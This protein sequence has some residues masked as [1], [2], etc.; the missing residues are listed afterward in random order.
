MSTCTDNNDISL[1][2]NRGTKL[3]ESVSFTGCGS[4]FVGLTLIPE[5]RKRV[6]GG[7][8]DYNILRNP[9]VVRSGE[10]PDQGECDPSCPYRGNNQRQNNYQQAP[11]P[12]YNQNYDR[13]APAQNQTGYYDNSQPQQNFG[14][15]GNNC[16]VP[17]GRTQP[18]TKDRGG[19]DCGCDPPSG[20]RAYRTPSSHYMEYREFQQ[21]PK[22]NPV[23]ER[24]QHSEYPAES[25]RT[26]RLQR[27]DS[28]CSC[29]RRSSPE[30]RQVQRTSR[31]Q[32]KVS[33]CSCESE[34]LEEKQPVQ[35]S[36][37]LQRKSSEC[38]CAA[39]SPPRRQQVQ[40]RSP[41]DK[42]YYQRKSTQAAQACSVRCHARS[43]VQGSPPPPAPK[44]KCPAATPP[45]TSRKPAPRTKSTIT[46][47][48]R[49][50]CTLCNRCSDEESSEPIDYVE[51]SRSRTEVL[52]NPLVQSRSSYECNNDQPHESYSE[53]YPVQRRTRSASCR[54]PTPEGRCCSRKGPP[55]CSNET[56]M[57][58]PVQSYR[59]SCPEN[60]KCASCRKLCP[61]C[62]KVMP[63]KQKSA[64]A[65]RYVSSVA[66]KCCPMCGL[67]PMMPNISIPDVA[68]VR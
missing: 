44:R 51:G 20:R 1:E 64:S 37:R 8:C 26:N 9:L 53:E 34:S 45:P 55:L 60:G 22:K 39:G 6:S 46:S 19:N 57:E 43:H 13:S 31:L 5:R 33:E 61:K 48:N 16:Y 56:L 28:D 49:R 38:S 40:R 32:K 25:Q 2:Q 7:D 63:Q 21:S 52:R 23:L 41:P 62:H 54:K 59:F 12:Y 47:R 14:S 10:I 18:Q 66:Q 11:E 27:N 67:L 17:P 4:H 36:N 65:K 30:R 15:P 29:E 35:R 50:K 68:S 42:S 3:K 58:K 24:P